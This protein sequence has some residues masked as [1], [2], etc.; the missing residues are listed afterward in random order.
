MRSP[1]QLGCLSSPPFVAVSTVTVRQAASAGKAPRFPNNLIISGTVRV[2]S[3]DCCFGVVCQTQRWE[4][5][6]DNLLTA[7]VRVSPLQRLLDEANI[8]RRTTAL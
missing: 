7:Q 4:G 3:E 6:P 8:V 1:H 5:A 2:S